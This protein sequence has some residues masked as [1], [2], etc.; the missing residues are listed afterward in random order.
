MNYVKNIDISR[1]PRLCG[2]LSNPS[3]N[4]LLN[5]QWNFFWGDGDFRSTSELFI[6]MEKWLQVYSYMVI[7][8]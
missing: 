8:S 4:I 3:L 5:T 7:K 6:D 2:R 1:F